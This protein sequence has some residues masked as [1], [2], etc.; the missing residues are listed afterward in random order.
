MQAID[1][2]GM[3]LTGLGLAGLIFGFENLG[4]DVLPPLAVAG[5]FAAGLAFIVLY[6]F[7]ARVTPNAVVDLKIFRIPTF[8]ASVARPRV[9]CS[10]PRPIAASSI[11]R[12]KNWS[13][14]RALEPC[15]MKSNGTTFRSCTSEPA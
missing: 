6:G 9:K 8:Q 13:S 5:L 11:T 15:C 12:R 2:L 10:T 7:H 4:R 14:P 1:W 3:A